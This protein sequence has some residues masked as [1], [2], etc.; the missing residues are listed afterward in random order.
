MI[1]L[2]NAFT[3]K[4]STLF[5]Y[6]INNLIRYQAY[7]NSYDNFLYYFYRLS[8]LVYFFAA[9]HPLFLHSQTA[10][11]N[12]CGSLFCSLLNRNTSL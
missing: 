12:S 1:F 8:F 2:I 10:F 7:N 9:T 4:S 6:M 5:Y 11:A 3:K